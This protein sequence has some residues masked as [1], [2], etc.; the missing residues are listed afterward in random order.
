MGRALHRARTQACPWH[1]RKR[2]ALSEKMSNSAHLLGAG[3]CWR[4]TA[5]TL[6]EALPVKPLQ[7]EFINLID[8]ARDSGDSR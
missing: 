7:P 1:A 4:D 3:H 5:P 8:D 6:I 2:S